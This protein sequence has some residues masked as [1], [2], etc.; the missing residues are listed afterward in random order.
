L[1]NMNSNQDVEEV[2]RELEKIETLRVIK[3]RP[4]R[5][6]VRIEVVS[7]T[8]VIQTLQKLSD[9]GNVL[10]K[11]FSFE[12]HGNDTFEELSK[13]NPSGKYI[14]DAIEKQKDKNEQSGK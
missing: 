13:I 14:M 5:N 11:D 3:I 8:Q 2:Q 4:D 12:L 7:G 10:F 1:P 6:L 9:S